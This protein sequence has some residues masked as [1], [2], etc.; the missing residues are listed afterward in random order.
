MNM[1]SGDFPRREAWGGA[2]PRT[3]ARQG[4]P[5]DFTKLF[6]G[7]PNHSIYN[8]RQ[9][10]ADEAVLACCRRAG[11]VCSHSRGIY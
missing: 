9:L 7:C 6:C 10:S 5:A 8:I 4:I 11:T 2:K 1:L 3:L